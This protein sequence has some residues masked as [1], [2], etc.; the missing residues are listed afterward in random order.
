[1]LENNYDEKS[2]ANEVIRSRID[3]AYGFDERSDLKVSKNSKN[4]IDPKV[5]SAKA[6][7]FDERSDLKESKIY[8]VLPTALA[9][10]GHTYRL[11]KIGKIQKE[12][13]KNSPQQKVSSRFQNHF[14]CRQFI[15]S[16]WDSTWS[17]WNWI[18]EHYRCCSCCNCV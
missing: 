10:E 11:Q 18:F 6:Y 5:S 12:I 3:R 15:A 9:D 13:E 17:C 7:G 1:M 14:F 4:F 2:N 16:Q 8:P